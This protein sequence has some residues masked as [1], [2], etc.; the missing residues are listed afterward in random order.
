ME[1]KKITTETNDSP[2]LSQRPNS[3]DEF[4]W[5]DAIKSVLSTAIDSAQKRN[6]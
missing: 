4:V 6:W 3:F 1:V 5:Q 2:L